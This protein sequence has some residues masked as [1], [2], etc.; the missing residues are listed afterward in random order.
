VNLVLIRVAKESDVARLAPRLRPEDR[1]ECL[2]VG[3]DPGTMIADSL[4][5]S[6][7]A[8][9]AERDGQIIAM[10]G[11]GAVGLFGEAEAWLLTAPEIERHKR[12]FLKLN[13][14]FIRDIFRFHDS[15]ICHVHADYCRAVRWLAW[16]GFQPVG[17]VT[18]NGAAF[19][20]MR[21]RRQ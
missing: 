9:A 17:T 7:E 4:A 6:H 19:L 10:W 18:V 21:L 14:D 8:F 15:I 2:A 5:A 20:Q 13:R 12:L 16:L 3:C 11:F 1:Q